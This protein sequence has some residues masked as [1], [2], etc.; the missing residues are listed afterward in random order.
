MAGHPR[1]PWSLE[2]E[3]RFLE[4][5]EATGSFVA[6]SQAGSP[7]STRTGARSYWRQRMLSHPEFAAKV[8]EAKA[9][10]LGR[11]ETVI[12]D[13]AING[14]EEPVYQMGRLAGHVRRYDHRLMLRVAAKLSE[15]WAEPQRIQV[16]GQIDTS[17]E[18]LKIKP[19]D[20]SLLPPER[21]E[22]FLALLKE[23]DDA[24]QKLSG[25]APE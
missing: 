23:M 18:L 5:L 16:S 14:V 20:L 1:F 19:E 17:S 6:A 24:Q 3:A 7:A 12:S 9:T 15:E 25:K 8:E 11:L 13:H 22:D 21:R 4:V 2:R 10:F